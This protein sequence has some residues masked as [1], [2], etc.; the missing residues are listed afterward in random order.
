VDNIKLSSE[1]TNQIKLLGK[2]ESDLIKMISETNN[3]LLMDKFLDW[4][5]QRTLCNETFAKLVSLIDY[6]QTN[7]ETILDSYKDYNSGREISPKELD[8]YEWI[9]GNYSIIIIKKS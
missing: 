4:Q 8:F 6:S 7:L 9:K 3:E 5:N 1:H 2:L